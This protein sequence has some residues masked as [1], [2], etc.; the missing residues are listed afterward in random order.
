ML[1]AQQTLE[2]SPFGASCQLGI[3]CRPK[4]AWHAA[5]LG[6]TPLSLVSLLLEFSAAPTMQA[7]RR[8]A[9]RRW[10]QLRWFSSSTEHH[11]VLSWGEGSQ[12]RVWD[13]ERV[14]VPVASGLTLWVARGKQVGFPSD[15][16]SPFA[17]GR[18]IAGRI[19]YQDHHRHVSCVSQRTAV[20]TAAVIH[21]SCGS[22]PPA[23]WH[24]TPQR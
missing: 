14:V 7:W 13:G 2:A 11:G 17:P 24:G 20:G 22:A 23:A 16:Q 18:A 4:Q 5:P 21:S 8:A 12:V 10:A 15:P 3:S 9:P 19:G 1:G 6:R